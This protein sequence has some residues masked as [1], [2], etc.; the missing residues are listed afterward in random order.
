MRVL[1]LDDIHH[2][3]EREFLE[4][5]TVAYVVVGGNGL[6]VV[7]DHHRTETVVADGVKGLYAAPIELDGR[8]D[9]VGA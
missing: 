5:E 1:H 7:V 3:F 2:T 4:I 9:T 6:R 8:T